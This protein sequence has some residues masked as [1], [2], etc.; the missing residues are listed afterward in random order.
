MS[1]GIS[2][3]YIISDGKFCLLLSYLCAYRTAFL[4][5]SFAGV[6][7]LQL[8]FYLLFQESYA[9]DT[10]WRNAHAILVRCLWA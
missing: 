3:I 7:H 4:V 10:K 5:L 9:G 2:H 6:E 1:D 8:E